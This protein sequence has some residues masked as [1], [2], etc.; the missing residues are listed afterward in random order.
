[1]TRY[2]HL[3]ESG[4]TRAAAKMAVQV[5]VMDS[6]IIAVERGIVALTT[7]LVYSYLC[8]GW[9]SV[10][11]AEQFKVKSPHVRALMK[12]VCDLAPRLVDGRLPEGSSQARKTRKW[13]GDR[14]TQLFMMR[15]SGVPIRKCAEV[16]GTGVSNIQSVWY[17]YFPGLRVITPK[18]GPVVLVDR[19]RIKRIRIPANNRKVWTPDKLKCLFWL[20]V[21]GLPF[22][23]LA[24]VLNVTKASAHNAWY[25]DLK[26]IKTPRRRKR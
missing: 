4:R 11:C 13:T 3:V 8:L 10:Q 5:Q 2:N 21:N 7:A 6:Q 17:N 15:T 14:L 18:N 20:R 9:T 22:S 24:K 19:I 16:F 25:K 23:D 26:G 12:R 1:M